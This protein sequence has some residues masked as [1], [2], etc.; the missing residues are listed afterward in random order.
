MSNTKL[1]YEELLIKEKISNYMINSREVASL[2][3]QLGS[4]KD[5]NSIG[6]TKFG[7]VTGTTN[8][9]SSKIENMVIRKLIIE[10][11]L[12]NIKKE[13]EDID[14]AVNQLKGDEKE[15]VDLLILEYKI[16]EI[17][18]KFN[19]KRK[20]IE[21]IRKRAFKKIYILICEHNNTK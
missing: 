11:Q 15:V 12:K 10:E 8:L 20:R 1:T 13:L 2:E 3:I 18:D 9:P 7:E 19:C 14:Y 17:A 6:S 21:I 16:S 4:L 5:M